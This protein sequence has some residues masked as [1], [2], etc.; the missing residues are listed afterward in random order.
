MCQLDLRIYVRYKFEFEMNVGYPND[1]RTFIYGLS[2]IHRV[3]RMLSVLAI[4]LFGMVS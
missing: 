4:L 3:N 2:L 1:I